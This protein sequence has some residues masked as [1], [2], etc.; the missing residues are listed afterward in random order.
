MIDLD[1]VISTGDFSMLPELKPGTTILDSAQRKPVGPE[2]DVI[3]VYGSVANPG[4]FPIDTARTVLQAVIAAGG[5]RADADVRSVRVR[6]AGSGSR[7]SVRGRSRGLHARRR[8]VLERAASS[9][10]YGDRSEESGVRSLA[11]HAGGGSTRWAGSWARFCSSRS[12]ETTTTKT[13][14]PRSSSTVVGKRPRP[15]MES[16]VPVRSAL[17]LSR[18]ADDRFSRDPA[19]ALAPAV[20]HLDST[21][22]HRDRVTRRLLF[23]EPQYE[24]VATLAVENPVQFT[25]TRSASDRYSTRR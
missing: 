20:C 1:N 24:S 16:R 15:P 13:T 7:A 4:T 2:G 18:K 9:G 17:V 25:R 23:M 21:A 3:F 10:R 6:T 19:H 12:G 8:A 14:A 5:P 11:L 22:A